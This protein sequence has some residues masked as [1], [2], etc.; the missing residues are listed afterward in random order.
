MPL[1][2]PSV[3]DVKTWMHCWRKCSIFPLLP[4]FCIHLAIMLRFSSFDVHRAQIAVSSVA[5]LWMRLF[6][7]F[8]W[9]RSQFD[10]LIWSCLETSKA[11]F[12]STS[13]SMESGV[14]ALLLASAMGWSSASGCWGSVSWSTCSSATGGWFDE[15]E[16]IGRGSAGKVCVG[17]S[18][19]LISQIWDL[20]AS[21]FVTCHKPNCMELQNVNK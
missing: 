6:S 11:W 5:W 18:L 10:H 13:S 12:S 1:S 9:K 20:C 19:V 7:F 21:V 2:D 17:S 4:P 8:A 14:P 15:A 3:S 16:A